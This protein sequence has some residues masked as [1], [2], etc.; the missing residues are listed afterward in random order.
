MRI[1]LV[2]LPPWLRSTDC[3]LPCL[4][5][6]FVC[7]FTLINFSWEPPEFHWILIFNKSGAKAGKVIK[8]LYQWAA[9]IYCTRG[10]VEVHLLWLAEEIFLNSSVSTPS[11][12]LVISRCR[13]NYPFFPFNSRGDRWQPSGKTVSRPGIQLLSSPETRYES[14]ADRERRLAF[15]GL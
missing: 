2:S 14:G 12:H 4:T 10:K 15:C 8:M 6:E 1:I 3:D 7:V 13:N 5:A 9:G 11:S